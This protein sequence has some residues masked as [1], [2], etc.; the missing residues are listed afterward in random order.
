MDVRRIV[1]AFLAC[2]LATSVMTADVHYTFNGTTYP[3]QGAAEAAMR[4]A[5]P[6]WGINL[7]VCQVAPRLWP[8][9]S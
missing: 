2:G 7:H 6:A 5:Y 1:F 8:V 4:A 3:S 9:A